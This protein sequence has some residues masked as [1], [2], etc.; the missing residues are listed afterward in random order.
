[1]QDEPKAT[2]TEQAAEELPPWIRREQ[3]KK[4]QDAD[5]ESGPP[6]GVLLL[7]SSL[8]AIASVRCLSPDPR[9]AIWVPAALLLV[10]G[11]IH[12]I[13]RIVILSQHRLTQGVAPQGEV[14]SMS[15]ISPTWAQH[16]L[17]TSRSAYTYE[18]LAHV[19]LRA[20]CSS[21]VHWSGPGITDGF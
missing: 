12:A 20:T 3:E 16:P 4:L 21:H 14:P 7:A 9:A 19:V 15:R 10:L 13:L 5:P 17:L 8:V 18:N 11:L 6:F 2:T 1:M